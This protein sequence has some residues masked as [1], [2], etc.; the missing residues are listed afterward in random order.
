V[1]SVVEPAQLRELQSS[2]EAVDVD[3]RLRDYVV[4]LGRWTRRDQRV[5]VGVSPRGVQRLFE[6]ARA[7]AVLDGRDYVIPDDIKGIVEAVFGHRLVLTADAELQ[8]ATRSDV[9]RDA[10]GGVAVPG[11]EGDAAAE[12]QPG[13]AE[14]PGDAGGQ[15]QQGRT[16][17]PGHRNPPESTQQNRRQNGNQQQDGTPQQ[18][19]RRNDGG[20]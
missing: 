17:Q 5:D 18:R 9:I 4:E 19:N 8:G 6:A 2:P 11:V 12:Q 3:P 1:V 13:A 10:L 14:Q 20:R 7:Q 16:H 15:T